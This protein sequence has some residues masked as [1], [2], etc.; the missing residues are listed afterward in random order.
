MT[1]DPSSKLKFLLFSIMYLKTLVCFKEKEFEYGVLRLYFWLMFLKTHVFG[2]NELKCSISFS[3]WIHW[4]HILWSLAPD[5]RSKF[6]IFTFGMIYVKAYV[7]L[8]VVQWLN[9]ASIS[10]IDHM[11]FTYNDLWP[12]IRGQNSKFLFWLRSNIPFTGQG[13]WIS[14]RYFILPYR[15]HMSWPLKNMQNLILFIS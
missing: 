6:I 4:G 13:D 9:I 11:N 5:K 2:A 12:L 10:H 15:G 14:H 7:F 1:S 3:F 8:G